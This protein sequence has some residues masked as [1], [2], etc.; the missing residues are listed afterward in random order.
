VLVHQRGY[1]FAR[2]LGRGFLGAVAPLALVRAVRS[3]GH[4]PTNEVDH[5]H[6][7]ESLFARY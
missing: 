4:Q 2:N 7:I 5:L 1:R 6:V 3:G